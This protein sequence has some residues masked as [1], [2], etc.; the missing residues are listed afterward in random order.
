MAHNNL[1]VIFQGQGNLDAAIAEYRKALAIDPAY[2]VA[3][4]NL[5]FLLKM[6]E[7]G[8]PEEANASKN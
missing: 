1:G 4:N 3:S 8:A 5:E 2:K 7:D 6:K